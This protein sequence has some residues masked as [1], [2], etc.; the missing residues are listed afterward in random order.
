MTAPVPG[1]IR[2]FPS[3]KDWEA[4]LESHHASHPGLWV[5]LY[6]KAS[7]VASMSY[8]QAL[9]G[10]LCYG[11]IDGPLRKGDARSWLRRFTPRRAGSLWSQVN[12]GHVE[13][14][15]REGR[16]RPAGLARVAEAKANGRWAQAY[17]PPSRSDA[18]LPE[19]FLKALARHKGAQAF[20]EGLDKANRYAIAYRLATAKKPETLARRQAAILAMLQE[21][22]AFHGPTA[23]TKGES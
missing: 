21:R 12:V 4:W 6:K 19:G 10:A 11:W 7:G 18:A 3:A 2:A 5:R 17:A 14:L 9:D 1:E 8:A 13:R 20:F 23:R 22:R 15:A 16:M